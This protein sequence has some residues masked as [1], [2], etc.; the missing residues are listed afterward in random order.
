MNFETSAPQLFCLQLYGCW[1]FLVLCRTHAR[2]MLFTGTLIATKC[3]MFSFTA[4]HQSLFLHSLQNRSIWSHFVTWKPDIKIQSVVT[5]QAAPS[6]ITLGTW[7][8]LWEKE[9]QKGCQSRPDPLHSVTTSGSRMWA[10]TVQWWSLQT[11]VV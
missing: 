10:A 8:Q 6:T 5:V 7:K 1:Y 9:V 3:R 4:Q 2:Q 11:V